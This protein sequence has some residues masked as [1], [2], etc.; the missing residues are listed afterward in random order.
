[1]SHIFRSD[2][3]NIGDR[4]VLRRTLPGASEREAQAAHTDIIGHII[5]INQGIS[6]LIRP[7]SAG[8]YPSAAEAI[9]VPWPEIHIMKKLSPRTIRNSDIRAIELAYAKA[10]PGIEHRWSDCG[11]WLLRAGDG[12]TE[13]SNS[14]APL[15]PSAPFVEVPVAEIQQ[16]YA[17]HHLPPLILL[18]ERI[19][20][21]A[22]RHVRDLGPEIIV[23]T[24][25]LA[26]LPTVDE[27]TPQDM[28]VE[29]RVDDTPDEQWLSLY[30]FRGATLPARALQLLRTEIDGTM[31][32]GRLTIDGTTVAITRGTITDDYLGYS[33][34]EVAP[35]YRRRGLGTL[36][37]AHM[38][39][40]GAHQG[41][42]T[43]YLQVIS[44]NTA[45]IGLYEK[46]GFTEHHR[47]RYGTLD[48]HTAPEN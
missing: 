29:F 21:A 19:G 37:G 7:Q 30:H 8:G 14:A 43:A 13:R 48:Q 6:V 36:L 41:A 44:T 45:G 17:S 11:Q 5:G 46:L 38:L 42:H 35:A 4:V 39:R 27:F 25:D 22:L 18:P 12:I 20:K 31:G 24:R 1:M 16:F 33:A 23:M 10:F 40:W 9:E 26:T 32:F 47:H 34:V 28:A 2:A 15:G 3:V